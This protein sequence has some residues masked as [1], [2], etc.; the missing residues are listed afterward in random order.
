MLSLGARYF[1]C[2]G[3]VGVSVV[4][5]E[6]GGVPFGRRDL[7]PFFVLGGGEERFEVVCCRTGEVEDFCLYAVGL[8]STK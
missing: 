8:I 1:D 4:E 3:V 7:G 6:R 5:V 2:L